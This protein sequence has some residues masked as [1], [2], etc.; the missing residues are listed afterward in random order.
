MLSTTD[1]PHEIKRCHEL[2]CST[3][4]TK[5][6]EYETF[7]EKIRHLGLFLSIVSVPAIDGD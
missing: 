6:V 5:P 4:I 7:V 1:Q 2:G 3:Y